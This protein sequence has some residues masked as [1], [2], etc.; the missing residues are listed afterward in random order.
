MQTERSPRGARLLRTDGQQK[1][2]LR[3]AI[4]TSCSTKTASKP[5]SGPAFMGKARKIQKA[6]FSCEP[7]RSEVSP[8][9]ANQRIEELIPQ[10]L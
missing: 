8:A 6:A 2:L 3:A 1:C 4:W 5:F 10:L 7:D 9:L